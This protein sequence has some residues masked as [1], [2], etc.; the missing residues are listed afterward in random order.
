MN[1]RPL[2]PDELKTLTL[3]A[4]GKTTRVIAEMLN[5]RREVVQDYL[6][7]AARK[8]GAANNVHAAAIAVEMKMISTARRF[9]SGQ[10]DC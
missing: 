5:I 7:T 3:Y 8:L 9:N 2:T 10:G 4:Q 6:R 1:A